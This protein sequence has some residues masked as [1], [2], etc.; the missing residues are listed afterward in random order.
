[1]WIEE[2]E[3]ACRAPRDTHRETKKDTRTKR[4]EECV[5]L[6][7]SG[8]HSLISRREQICQIQSLGSKADESAKTCPH[9]YRGNKHMRKCVCGDDTELY[10]DGEL[11]PGKLSRSCVAPHLHGHTI[12][13]FPNQLM[14]LICNFVTSGYGHTFTQKCSRL[15]PFCC[16][17]DGFIPVWC[18]WVCLCF[19]WC[20]HMW[21]AKCVCR[22]VGRG[23]SSAG[24]V[25][26]LRVLEGWA[27][28][29]H[30]LWALF[31]PC[32]RLVIG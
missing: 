20:Q 7:V 27:S 31:G 14:V 22:S 3:K 5:T 28:L 32:S 16:R 18:M 19:C 12:R 9:C 23:E 17:L 26:R 8:C 25:E 15:S 24:W 29:S 10:W 21:Q 1:M 13:L 2:G 4:P 6:P 11:D 30:G